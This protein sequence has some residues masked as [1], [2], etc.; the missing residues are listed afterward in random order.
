VTVFF[1]DYLSL[2]FSVVIIES[3]VVLE[4]GDLVHLLL[5]AQKFKAD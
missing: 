3:N 2:L 4:I 5:F 1:G